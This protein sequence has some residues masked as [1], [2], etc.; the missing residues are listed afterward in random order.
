MYIFFGKAKG[1][2]I[3]SKYIATT[4]DKCHMK[5]GIL[6]MSFPVFCTD[7]FQNFIAVLSTHRKLS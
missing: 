1:T 5:W 6:T 4:L 7:Y 3:I 2:K